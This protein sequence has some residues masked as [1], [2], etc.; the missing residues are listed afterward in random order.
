MVAAEPQSTKGVAQSVKKK[1]K[2]RKISK[3]V[4]KAQKDQEQTLDDGATNNTTT[5]TDS[6]ANTKTNKTRKKKPRATKNS[7][8]VANY[9]TLWKHEQDGTVPKGS[10]W[11]F[12]KNT[13][14]WLIRHMYEA[15]KVSK[16]QFAILLEYLQGLQGQ[17]AKTRIRADATDRALR[18]KAFE[19]EQEKGGI[20]QKSEDCDEPEKEE[21]DPMKSDM[22]TQDD[23]DDEVRWKALNA[24]DKRKEYK[25]T[26]QVLDTIKE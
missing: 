26:R 23:V 4:M 7:A 3:H 14:S 20:P 8:D 16:A 25:R 15:D 9:L 12:N 10:A 2:K 18:Y 5:I 13:Q 6:N 19:A 11:K 24:H 22:S 21:V 17:D 1:G